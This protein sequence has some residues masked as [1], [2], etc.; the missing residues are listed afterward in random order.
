MGIGTGVFLLLGFVVIGFLMMQVPSSGLRAWSGP[1]SYRVTA[2]FDDIGA[3]KI[4]APVKMGG[5][6][7][8]RVESISFDVSDYRA[9]VALSLE[10]RFDQIPE[11]SDAAIRAAGLL[12][13]TYVV[14]T[15]GGASLFL[16]P[17]MRIEST[18]SAFSIERLI[19][20]LLAGFTKQFVDS[21]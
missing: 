3:L 1:R 5:V 2:K 18:Q 16:S 10:R 7:I 14:V 17:G 20:K 11:D 13:G 6:R 8:G 12:G 4:D 15:P 21:Q 9:V 19:N